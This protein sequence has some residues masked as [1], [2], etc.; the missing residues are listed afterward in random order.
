MSAIRPSKRELFRMLAPDLR[1]LKGEV[2]IDASRGDKK[3]RRYFKTDRY[4]GDDR[5]STLKPDTCTHLDR[6]RLP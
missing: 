6:P 3:N 4:L 2:G 5:N 1:N